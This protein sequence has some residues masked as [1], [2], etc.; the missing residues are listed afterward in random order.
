MPAPPHNVVK[1][2]PSIRFIA[3][4]YIVEI[5]IGFLIVAWLLSMVAI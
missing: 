4:V 5:A 1:F 3:V 2:G